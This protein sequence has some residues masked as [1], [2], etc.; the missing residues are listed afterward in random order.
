MPG[1]SKN[2]LFFFLLLPSNVELI[3][4]CILQIFP[5]R[6]LGQKSDVS[7]WQRVPKREG[8]ALRAGLCQGAQQVRLLPIT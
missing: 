3:C 5:W 7:R 6:S 8:G 4:R 1:F 2:I